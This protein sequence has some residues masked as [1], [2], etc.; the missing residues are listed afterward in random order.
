MVTLSPSRAW[1]HSACSVYI[2]LPSAWRQ[3]TGRSGA[4]TAAPVAIGSPMPMAP[5]GEG[6]PVVGRRARRRA[7]DEETRRVALVH[8]DGALGQRGADGGRQRLRGERRR[9][10]GRTAR[11]CGPCRPS[12]RRA[13]ALRPAPPGRRRRP[14]RAGPACARCSRAGPGRSPCRG[15]RRR[16]PG[17]WRR[18]G[19]GAGR[20]R[21]G[22]APSRPG[23]PTAPPPGCP[24]PARGWPGRSRRSSVAPGRRPPGWPPAGRRAR[25]A[26]AA[27]EQS[28]RAH[29][30]A[31][32]WPPRRRCRRA[33][34]APSPRPWRARPAADSRPRRRPPAA[35]A[36][37][38]SPGGPAP[39]PRRRPRRAATSSARAVERYHPETAPAIDA[40]SDCSG[41][42]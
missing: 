35:P 28:G 30:S 13:D 14:R 12:P 37:R 2:A 7:R 5:A 16:T 29:P 24:A 42:S 34:T 11:R 19:R 3:R 18:P 21:A 41:A 27:Q 1:V 23:R 33:P 9:W 6:Q 39:P 26:L 17:T 4:A 25:S 15:R 40:M 8:D 38:R 20:R 22:P 31:A 10:G 32:P 36:W